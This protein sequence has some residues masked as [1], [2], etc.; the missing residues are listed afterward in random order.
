MPLK[1]SVQK[2]QKEEYK[3]NKS[4]NPSII[5]PLSSKILQFLSCHTIQSNVIRYLPKDL[6]SIGAL[7]ISIWNEQYTENTPRWNPINPS[8]PE[9]TMP[10]P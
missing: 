1:A 6:A 4:H 9:E 7:Q 8:F 2:A 5:P 3:W 10:K